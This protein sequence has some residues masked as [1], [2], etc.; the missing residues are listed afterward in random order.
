MPIPKARVDAFK[1]AI[2]KL[3]PDKKIE[4]DICNEDIDSGFEHEVVVHD[5]NNEELMQLQHPKA[6]ELLER[7]VKALE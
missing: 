2:Q 4:I 5:E 6:F 1:T 7:F 3:W